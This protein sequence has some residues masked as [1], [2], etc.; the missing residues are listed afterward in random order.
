MFS[1]KYKK[2][3][4]YLKYIKD[5]G[6][7][8]CGKDVMKCEEIAK[9]LTEFTGSSY[10]CLVSTNRYLESSGNVIKSKTPNEENY[11]N[12]LTLFRD[13]KCIPSIYLTTQECLKFVKKLKEL[14]GIHYECSTTTGIS[15]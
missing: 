2:I 4:E 11:D 12:L 1:E 5:N 3:I 8:F 13:Y 9:E 6:R 15:K 14:T 10:E 7:L